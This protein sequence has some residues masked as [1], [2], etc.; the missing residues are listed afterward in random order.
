MKPRR[1]TRPIRETEIVAKPPVVDFG[2]YLEQN[3]GD[4]C[5]RRADCVV[6]NPNGSYTIKREW[7]RPGARPFSKEVYGFKKS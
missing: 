4:V 6:F 2:G 3:G 1:K 7:E 5:L